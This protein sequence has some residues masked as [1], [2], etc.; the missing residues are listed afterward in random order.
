ME[1][2]VLQA[3]SG[4]G[5]SA[6][7]LSEHDLWSRDFESVS[8]LLEKSHTVR[9]IK[10]MPVSSQNWRDVSD[11]LIDIVE[12]NKIRASYVVAF[13]ESASIALHVALLKGKLIRRLVL[14]NPRF[15]PD[16]NKLTQLIDKIE[17]ILP[18][19]LPFRVKGDQF[20]AR[21]FL[22]RIRFPVLVIDTKSVSREE[23][24]SELINQSLPTSWY[25]KTESL[26]S[27]EVKDA[28]LE[29][30]DVPAKRP[31]KKRKKA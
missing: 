23:K 12:Q 17:S 8:K 21:P 29:F 31:Q 4:S 30:E 9:Q 7:V 10:L 3:T 28:L 16:P 22:Q 2:S 14:V 5:A 24:E 19:G 11:Q 25:L 1:K 26:E 20:D 6:I 27:Q 15:R 18:L 13:G